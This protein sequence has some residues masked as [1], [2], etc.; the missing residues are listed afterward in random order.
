[1]R[2]RR[3]IYIEKSIILKG[4]MLFFLGTSFLTG[5]SLTTKNSSYE[6]VFFEGKEKSINLFPSGVFYAERGA[7]KYHEGDYVGGRLDFLKAIKIFDK[8]IDLDSTHEEGYLYRGYAKDNIGDYKGAIADFTKVIQI[9]PSNKDA[10]SARGSSKV[11]L[12][13]YKSGCLDYSKAYAL[14]SDGAKIMKRNV[15]SLYDECE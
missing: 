6:E 11:S 1:M 15:A 12:G 10:Y 4:F 14:G 13:N 5:C 8:V 9:N 3:L 7:E 2:K